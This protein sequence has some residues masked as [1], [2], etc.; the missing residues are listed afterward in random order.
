MNFKLITTPTKDW[1]A[2]IQILVNRGI[3]KE[4]IEH[5][6]HTSDEDINSF[7]S[8]GM[9]NLKAAAAALIHAIQ[10]NLKAIIIVDSDC[11]GFTSSALLINYLHDLFPYWV[12]NCLDYSFHEGKQ[13]GLAD[14]IGALL[15]CNYSLV[16]CPDS[17]SND[18]IEH[19]ELAEDATQVIVL[20]HHEAERISENAIVINNQLSDYPNKDLSGVGVTWQ[21]CRYIDSI[22]KTSYADKYLDLVAL[23]NLADMMSLKSYETKYLIN[24]GFKNIKNPFIYYMAQKNAFKLGTEITPMG[25]AFYIAPFVNAMNRS[26]TLAEKKLL[27]DSMLNHKAFQM[28][29]STKRG[30]KLGEQEKLVEQAIRTATNVKNRQTREENKGLELLEKLIEKNNLL[31][32]KVL[33]FLLEPGQ[34]DRNIAGLIANKFMAKYQR[35]CCILT[36]TVRTDK[37]ATYVTYEGSARGYSKSGVT[38]FKDICEKAPGVIYAEGH[39]GAFGLGIKEGVYSCCEDYEAQ[40]ENI[41]QFINYMDDFFKDI[42]SEPVYNV[43]YI[44]E[45]IDVD[46]QNILDIGGLNY[47]WG[48]DVD[49]PYVAIEHLKITKDMVTIYAKSTN[50]LKIILPNKVSLMKFNVSEEECNKFQTDG[51]IELNVVGRCNINEYNGW[52]NAQVMIE[53]YEIIDSAKY[54]F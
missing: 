53:D 3:E 30:H 43:D 28:I 25:A 39:Q 34:I 44:Y 21:F 7:E 50:T 31:E 2:I 54:F 40:G 19:K 20:D 24:K 52:I 42:S 4:N 23:G 18:Y 5:Y 51:F 1:E 10:N 22:M 12:E 47:L 6:L 16:I 48:Q 32:H 45:G 29:S 33:L 46:P 27:F 11:D 41:I 38:N 9:D 14:H 49:E 13:H 37:E 26:G 17:S 8:L 36:K 15:E 35:P